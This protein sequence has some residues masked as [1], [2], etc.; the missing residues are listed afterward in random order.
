MKE[1]KLRGLNLGGF[2][3]A[4]L[5][6]YGLLR[7]LTEKGQRA[8]LRFENASQAPY[9]VISTN[10]QDEGQLVDW[11][12]GTLRDLDPV[13][14]G[15]VG[16]KVMVEKKSGGTREKIE[17][18]KL[19][20]LQQRKDVSMDKAFQ[21]AYFAEGLNE[22]YTPF[23]TTKG[24][25]NFLKVYQDCREY[26]FKDEK[27]A[28]EALQRVL[29]EGVLLLPNDTL[30][31]ERIPRI[32]WHHSQFRRTASQA[33]ITNL[34]PDIETVRLNPAAIVLAWEA[35]PLF[36]F[37]PRTEVPL[38]FSRNGR[39]Y[40]L[41]IPTPPRLVTLGHLR[42]L[43]ALAPSLEN[44]VP[45]LPVWVSERIGSKAQQDDYPCFLEARLLRKN[46]RAGIYPVRQA[47]AEVRIKGELRAGR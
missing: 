16:E 30:F 32:G 20:E 39:R 21:M 46:V 41:Y 18:L 2:P 7:L 6:A 9:A 35:L 19:K 11:L 47:F 10:L 29:F 37:P 14:R 42:A 13:T 44:R 36:P 34:E 1:M 43:I 45:D 33:R 26:L 27:R 12:L 28:R 40:R 38:G 25:Q 8:R 24:Q 23:D 15:Y 4:A 5:A 22:V 3:L 31:E 17:I